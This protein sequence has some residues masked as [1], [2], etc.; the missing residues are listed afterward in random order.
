MQTLRQKEADLIKNQLDGL[1]VYV[2]GSATLN[3]VFDR[4]MSTKYDLRK[5]TRS[6]YNYMYDHFVR[7]GFGQRKIGEIKYSDVMYFYYYLLNE[8]DLQANTVDTIHTVLHPT[9]QLAVRDGIIRTNPSDG[10]MVS[11]Q[12]SK[13]KQG[14]TKALDTL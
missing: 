13:E 8:K 3:F 14:R 2:A 5:T 11:W 4:Y 10:V 9:F 1:D 12:K 6:N 7:D